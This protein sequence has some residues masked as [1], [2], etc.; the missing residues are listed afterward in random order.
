MHKAIILMLII[1]GISSSNIY[2]LILHSQDRG[3][4]C[5]DGSPPAMYLNEGTG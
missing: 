3:A 1:V 4:A 5:L 2:N